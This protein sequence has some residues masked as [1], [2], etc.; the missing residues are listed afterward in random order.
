MAVCLAGLT[1]VFSDSAR[2]SPEARQPDYD[3]AAQ[4]LTSA[5]EAFARTSGVGLFYK[6]AV[7]EGRTSTPVHGSMTPQSALHLLLMDTGLTAKFTRPGAA[8]I[9]P[10]S[11]EPPPDESEALPSLRLDMME[12][13]A[14]PIIGGPDRAAYQRYAQAALLDIYRLL[15]QDPVLSSRAFS[16]RLS[17]MIDADGKIRRLRFIEGSGDEAC[18]T[19]ISRILVGK[20]LASPPAT[21]NEALYFEVRM[22]TPNGGN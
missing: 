17:M 9:Y 13:R 4:P 5:L 15:R 16:V 12:V 11:G 3:I 1:I 21:L 10:A 18:D 2:A 8:I 14:A 7:T 20:M 19:Q 22:N 6:N